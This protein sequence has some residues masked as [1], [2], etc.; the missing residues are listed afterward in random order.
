MIV[1]MWA[2][3][4]VLITG[5]VSGL[6]L[7]SSTRSPRKIISHSRCSLPWHIGTQCNAGSSR[8]EMVKVKSHFYSITKV[9]IDRKKKIM[10]HK[11]NE[12]NCQSKLKCHFSSVTSKQCKSKQIELDCCRSMQCKSFCKVYNV[13]SV[14]FIS[15]ALY[16]PFVFTSLLLLRLLKWWLGITCCV[17]PKEVAYIRSG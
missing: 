12:I 4:S 13:T 6:S 1:R 3:L 7:F 17:R 9:T 11:A 2:S 10:R 16:A 5:R 14:Q 15:V 8:S